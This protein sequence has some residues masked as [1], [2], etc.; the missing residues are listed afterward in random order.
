M[1]YNAL[2]TALIIRLRDDYGLPLLVARKIVAD[3]ETYDSC[4]H[5]LANTKKGWL[6]R[7]YLDY[8]ESAELAALRKNYNNSSSQTTQINP[9]KKETHV[10]NNQ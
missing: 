1:T 6:D 4:I 5:F 8:R 3:F 9:N 2:N 10:K 7:V